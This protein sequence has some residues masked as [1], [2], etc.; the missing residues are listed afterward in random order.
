MSTFDRI[1]GQVTA[2]SKLAIVVMLVVT[3]GLAVGA[4]EVESSS[5]LDQFQTDSTEADKLDY[6]DANF[7]TGDANTTTAQVI[8]RDEGGNVL[9]KETLL[10]TLEYQQAIRTDD[11]TADSLSGDTP[12]VGVANVIAVADRR[13]AEGRD[14]RRVATR[15]RTLNES[16]QQRRAALEA[17]R[18]AL[19]ERQARLEANQSA[20]QNRSARLNET[21][22][23]LR[24]GLTELR[25]NP[26]QNV[27]RTFAAVRANSSVALNETD[28]GIFRQA[29]RSLRTA[30][31]QSQAERAYTLGTQGVLRDDYAEVRERGARLRERGEQLQ[32]DAEAL[33]ER[34]EQLQAD[35]ERLR[36]L[37]DELEAERAELE[38]ASDLTLDEQIAQL[39]EMN[40][41]EV[42]ET[43]EL[44]LGENAS[45]SGGGAF[46]FMPTSYEPGSTEAEATMLLVT[47]NS[48]TESAS[49]GAASGSLE[50]AQS[51]MQEIAS[52]RDDGVE[53]LIFGS[54][55]ISEEITASQTDSVQIVGPLAALFVLLALIVA[56]R[57]VVD[58]LLG[59]G[60]IAAVLAWTFGFMGWLGIDFNQIFVAVPVLLIG[61]SID[62]A[63]HIFMRHRE[64]RTAA[65]DD[66]GTRRSMTV[67]LGGVGIALVWVT[68]TT[69]IGFLS[70]LTSPVPPIRDFGVVSSF[71]ITA[72]FLIFG[73]LIPALKVEIDEL[74]E[75][76]G[77][78]RRKR[79][80]GTGG[81]AFSSVL[82]VG[83]IAARRAPRVVIALA[84]IVTVVAGVGGTQVD[85]SFSQEDFLAEQPPEWMDELPEE[86]R[87]GNYTA[88]ANLQYVND[89]FVREDSQA[90]VLVE[91][92]DG[93]VTDPETLDRLADAEDAATD[94]VGD[95]GVVQALSNGEADIQ[96]PLE[97]M[98]SVAADNETFRT[99][100]EAADTDDD[101]VPEENVTAVYDT[102]YEVA[103]D[104]AA[105]VIYRT[106]DGAYEAL[107]L[108]VSIQ[109]GSAGADVT[110]QMREIA[111]VADDGDGGVVVTATGNSILN[112]IV[113][114]QLL[115]TVVESLVITLVA[116][117]LFLMATYRVTEGSASLGAV[118]LLPVVFSVAWILGTMFVA[119]IPFNVL[120]G[121]ITSL[122][123]GLGV[124]YSIHLSE[125]YNQEL[126]RTG[127]VFDA[128]DRTVTGTGGAL[129][130]SAAT[131]AGG[132]GVLVFAILPPLQQ[133]GTITA[134][135][136][137]YAFLA[138]VL[139][140]PSMLVVWTSYVGPD[141]AAAQIR[142]EEPDDGPGTVPTGAAVAEA[143]E[144]A[145][146]DG[147]ER[148][149]GPAEQSDGTLGG[150]TAEDGATADA[151]ATADGRTAAVSETPADTAVSEAPADGTV[152]EASTDAAAAEPTTDAT[153][154]ADARPVAG[155]WDDAEFVP[156][157]VVAGEPHARR[158]VA[159]THVAPGSSVTATI[160][161][162]EGDGRFLLRER[163]AGPTLSVVEATPEPVD[164][165]E[166]DSEL[167]VAWE[168]S[169]E[170]TLRYEIHVPE[171]AADGTAYSLDGTLST[172]TEDRTVVG[173]DTVQVVANLFERIVS[174][175][176]V[177]DADL[178]LARERYEDDSLSEAQF[179]RVYRAWLRDGGSDTP[180]LAE[181]PT[182]DDT[183]ETDTSGGA[184]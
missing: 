158:E 108:V 68:A 82:S 122:T 56:Y 48:D 23:Q 72:A 50:D 86:I 133:F 8:V 75:R 79:A 168:T 135:T 174:A 40:E 164:V 99:T 180:E 95:D 162:S 78:D 64:E 42:D 80:F 74:L 35:A 153:E 38:N 115:E 104:R 113:Q 176:T 97:T 3:A 45:A 163:C 36:E 131:T 84:L 12:T 31:N 63:I 57:D 89:N 18:T 178:R 43:V 85:T 59:L 16:V 33:E 165:F 125:R 177:S 51:A 17:N 87:P 52:E 55:I 96:S 94:R 130:G 114:D 141:W 6:I 62:Y 60:G 136:I 27:T 139:I 66:V 144:T 30:R 81:G 83:S 157:A 167:G 181:G 118:T 121:T 172:D 103:P 129:L 149:S 170:A 44:V 134:M 69:V 67:A 102:L 90:Q 117:F 169:G 14:V 9:D 1:V 13:Q 46:G 166:R 100:F 41:S 5:S 156:A 88:K 155:E 138:S 111:D 10:D 175:G 124:A 106:D 15:L 77:V 109:G 76:V 173:E 25:Q 128:M 70:N 120:T 183:S 142:G 112:K 65:A 182:S 92:G 146:T 71:G 28:L 54:G 110:D 123:V 26:R 151:G 127:D 7:S 154:A 39:R 101:G 37:A 49:P 11:R 132:F 58:I 150:G 73:V 22:G 119:D 32:A 147:R 20:L 91:A 53:Y 47:Q 126:E 107:R 61:L 159:T 184:G 24:A 148:T 140:L 34:G 93:S 137:V 161:V 171:D 19:R 2:H 160:T 21:A 29:A 143:A 116:V 105:G 145:G 179:D 98:Q 4:S 152:A